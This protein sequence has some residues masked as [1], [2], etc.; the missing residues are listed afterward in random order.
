MPEPALKQLGNYHIG[1]R[2]GGGG[3][4]DVFEAT[5]TLIGRRAAIKVLHP[6][7][8]EN[9]LFVS[10]FLNEAR[11]VNLVRHPGLV[12]IYEFGTLPDGTAYIVMEYLE[13]EILSDRYRR[14]GANFGAA[15]LR[16]LRLT[17]LAL[18]AAHEKG[19]V[20]RDLKPDNVMVVKDP[21]RPGEERVKVLDFGI[22]KMAEPPAAGQ[23]KTETGMAMGTVHYMSP[24]QC[25]A[26]PLDDKSDVYSLGV[27]LYQLVAGKRPF[28]SDLA[29]EVMVLHVRV[30][31]RPVRELNPTVSD[32]LAALLERMMAKDRTARPAMAEAAV[33]LLRL[34]QRSLLR[35]PMAAAVAHTLTHKVNPAP[36]R[37]GRALAVRAAAFL[38]TLAVVGLLSFSMLARRTGHGHMPPAPLHGLEAAPPRAQPPAQAPEPEPASMD[39]PPEPPPAAER[40]RAHVH[41]HGHGHGVKAPA[42][43]PSPSERK[44]PNVPMLPLDDK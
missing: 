26:L 36:V 33:E 4:G 41:A 32:E 31:P 37:T 3:M 28:E 35:R 9:P 11:S 43:G 22:A 24:E 6:H 27:M 16:A 12:E 25:Q 15:E 18:A 8:S 17:A 34:E 7:L 44:A 5:H 21:E 20:H 1:R 42:P 10:R 23:V 38:G 40:K 13:G 2:L 19:I 29:S 14:V 39:T 30:P